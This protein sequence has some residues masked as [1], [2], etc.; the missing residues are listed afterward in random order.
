MDPEVLTWPQLVRRAGSPARARGWLERGSWRRVLRGAYAPS[1]SGDSTHLRVQALRLVLPP[2]VALSHRTALW[3][4]GI[5]VLQRDRLTGYELLDVTTTRGL[6]LERRPGL[7]THTAALPDEELCE[8]DGLLLVSASRAFVDV[9]RSDALVEAVAFGDAVLRS[10]AADLP[11]LTEALERAAGL[12]GICAART[13]LPHL[14]SR[15]ESL[16]E[17]RLRMRLVLGG[18]PRPDSQLDVYDDEGHVGRTDLHLDGVVLEYD[19]R[20]ARLLKEVFVQERRRQTRLA[21]LGLE[22]R[23]F[24]SADYYVRPALAVCAE[25][26]RALDMARARDRSRVRSGP[27]TLRR[28]RLAPLPT[29]A[30]AAR[31]TA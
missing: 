27:D 6:H 5:D 26:R 3:A 4:R 22:I 14:E 30:D 24:T 8:L 18:L 25:V 2:G 21:E 20:E 7:R 9:A 16:M 29:R 17:S 23:R 10:G 1:S 15:S 11:L 31:R 13:V 28:P 12:R 19:G